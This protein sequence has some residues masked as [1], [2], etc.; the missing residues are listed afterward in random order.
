M[1]VVI[2]NY[3]RDEAIELLCDNMKEALLDDAKYFDS[4]LKNG[5]AGF[6]DCSNEELTIQLEE[7]FDNGEKIKIVE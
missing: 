5:F 1:G 3:T 6:D 4:I 2:M 7:Y